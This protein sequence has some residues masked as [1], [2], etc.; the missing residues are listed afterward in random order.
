MLTNALDIVLH[1]VRMRIIQTLL[2]GRRLTPLQ[3]ARRLSEVPQATLYRHINKLHD[4]GILQVVEERKV[5]GATEKVYQ[6]NEEKAR[7]SPQEVKN[8]SKEDHIRYFFAFLTGLQNSFLRYM[9][10][11]TVDFKRD[12]AGY[13]LVALYLTDEEFE[14]MVNEIQKILL[15]VKDN[16][17]APGRK[18]RL[19]ATVIIPDSDTPETP[20]VQH[21]N[22]K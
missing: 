9:E 19:L 17:P 16:S 11:E 7:P 4:A 10:Q 1:P 15:S 6:L 22:E 3:L 21:G 5:R 20:A 18:R 13:H 2:G 8:I 14:K 12:G